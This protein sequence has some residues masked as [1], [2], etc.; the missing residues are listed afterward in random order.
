MVIYRFYF[1]LQKKY[2]K[3]ISANDTVSYNWSLTGGRKAD[4][5]PLLVQ[6]VNV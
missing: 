2:E 1:Y 4:F 6:I 3:E 5:C